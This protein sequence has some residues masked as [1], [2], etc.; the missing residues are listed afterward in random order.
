MKTCVMSG[1][2]EAQRDPS[3]DAAGGAGDDGDLWLGVIH[4]NL[5]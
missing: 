4:V 3:T 2:G 5:T 1:T